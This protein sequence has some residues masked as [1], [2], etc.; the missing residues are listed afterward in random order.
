M[1]EETGLFRFIDPQERGRIHVALHGIMRDA[2]ESIAS[3]QDFLHELEDELVGIF[4]G[5][6]PLNGDVGR[7][8]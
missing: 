8:P 5:K 1:K 3:I 4:Y 2:Y 7:W 6:G